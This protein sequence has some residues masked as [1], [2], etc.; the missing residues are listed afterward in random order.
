MNQTTTKVNAFG[1][2]TF[3]YDA[4]GQLSR[5]T[6]R[7][8]RMRDFDYDLTGHKNSE[9]WL[10]NAGAT[11]Q[12]QTWT[13][14]A[15]GR[16]STA[17]NP[18]GAYTYSYDAANRVTEVDEPW[19]LVLTY[20]YDTAGN[21]NSVKD[22]K[23]GVTTITF[24]AMNRQSSEAEAGSGISAMRFDFAYTDRGQLDTETRYSDLAGTTVVARTTFAYDDAGPATTR[25]TG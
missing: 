6:D 19:N 15:A 4:A 16:L 7:L 1:T 14:D 21:R 18:D 9:V 8:G 23:G 10:N 25:R 2:T 24:D 13:Y 20:G 22:S 17:Q 5:E 11:L 12:L 3:A